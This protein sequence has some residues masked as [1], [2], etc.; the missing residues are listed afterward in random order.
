MTKKDMA[1]VQISIEIMEMNLNNA[2][3]FAINSI[4]GGLTLLANMDPEAALDVI[5]Q[6][7]AQNEELKELIVYNSTLKK[8]KVEVLSEMLPDMIEFDEEDN[9]DNLFED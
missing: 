9:K 1:D 3:Q 6:L 5:E 8:K 4:E 7:N 2:K